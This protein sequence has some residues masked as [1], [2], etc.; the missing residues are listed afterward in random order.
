MK[1]KSATFLL[2]CLSA[3]QA[4]TGL[5]QLQVLETEAT[6]RFDP[7]VTVDTLD[8]GLCYFIRVNSRPENR[9]ELRLVVNAGSV[10]E[11]EDQRGLAHFV[12]HMAFN[13]TEGFPKQDLVDYLERIG[14]RFGPD[15]NAYT[16]FDETVYMLQVPTD[17]LQ[18][19][20]TAFQILEE[21]AHRLTFD[22]DMVEGER[23]VVVEE[24]RLGRG[25]EARMFDR[26]FPILFQGSQYAQRLPVG[27][28]DAIESF[29]NEALERFYRD[30]Y[31]PDTWPSSPSETSTV[32]Q[33][34]V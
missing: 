31:R 13:G 16:G 28:K 5:A 9:A 7:H 17:S 15:L 21:W 25:A 2:F 24:W 10:L 4:S 29:D 30:W 6:L 32:T 11:D 27:T 3:G 26:Q 18:Q 1:H 20:R 33:W 12:E 8:N 14:M 22:P 23:G 34:R 19:L